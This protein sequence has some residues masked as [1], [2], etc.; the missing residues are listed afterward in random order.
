MAAFSDYVEN[1]VGNLLL[2]GTALT[3]PATI[4]LALFTTNPTDA[5]TGTE[6]AGGSY[7]RQVIT[8]GAPTNGVFSN[9]ST[10]TYGDM[11]AATVSHWGIYDALAGGNLLYHGAWATPVEYTAGQTAHV[12]AD[13][14]QITHQ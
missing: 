1:A 9:D 2:R 5:G 6:V 13:Q 10:C 12:N 8:F 11:P 14:V 7:A 3:S 4:Y